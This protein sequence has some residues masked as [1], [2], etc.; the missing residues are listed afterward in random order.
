MAAYKR[1]IT[2]NAFVT[3]IMSYLSQ[4]C[5]IPTAMVNINA[6]NRE[7]HYFVD[8]YRS[9]GYSLALLLSKADKL[10]IFPALRSWWAMNVAALGINFDFTS[11]HTHNDLHYNLSYPTSLAPRDHVRTAALEF[12]S[13]FSDWKGDF[14]ISLTIYS[15]QKKIY[16]QFVQ[17]G[18]PAGPALW[19]RKL[20]AM[21]SRLSLSLSQL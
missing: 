3:P 18:F 6:F 14:P 4:F 7:A 12:L 15:S 10:G 9:K 8:N 1:I 20:K 19:R 16:Q 2:L 17:H 11:L 21:D 5:L 13:S